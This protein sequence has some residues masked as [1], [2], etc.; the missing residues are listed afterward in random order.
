MSVPYFWNVSTNLPR[1]QQSPNFLEHPTSMTQVPATHLLNKI[2][3]E[4]EIS[5]LLFLWKQMIINKKRREFTRFN[6]DPQRATKVELLP[7]NPHLA[8][9]PP[10]SK[11]VRR[12]QAPCASPKGPSY[13]LVKSEPTTTSASGP[14]D[15]FDRSVEY[16]MN[17]CRELHSIQ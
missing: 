6:L 14:K 4:D 8:S 10:P 1:H 16:L 13:V 17:P 11:Y 15:E 2:N 5:T 12:H 7:G 9:I 3:Q